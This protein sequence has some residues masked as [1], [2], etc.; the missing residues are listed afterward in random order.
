[1]LQL[2]VEPKSQPWKGWMLPLHHW[3][4][5]RLT[6]QGINGGLIFEITI[7]S[8]GGMIRTCNLPRI[9]GGVLP[10][11]LRPQTVKEGFEPPCD[12]RTRLAI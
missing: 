6:R 2:G 1:M 8:G 12:Y 11:K 5:C 9:T 10:I 4:I 7:P 3:S